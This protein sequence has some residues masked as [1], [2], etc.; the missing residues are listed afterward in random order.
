[1]GVKKEDI[2]KEVS[3]DNFRDLNRVLKNTFSA[4]KKDLEESSAGTLQD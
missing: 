1:M 4:L 2:Y 3:I